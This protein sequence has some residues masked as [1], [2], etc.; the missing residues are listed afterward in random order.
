MQDYKRDMGQRIKLA[1][2]KR[3]LTQE[4]ASEALDVS[5][6]HFSEVERG[7]AGLSVESLIRLSD[8]LG[9]ST[10]YLLKGTA[11][12]DAWSCVLS[13]L[14]QTPEEKEEAMKALLNLAVRL[15]QD[16]PQKQ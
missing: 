11:D 9:V 4:K 15:A 7:L 6:K 13:A 2:K 12:A 10:D 14:R 1:R 16:P 5:V 3:G 8:L